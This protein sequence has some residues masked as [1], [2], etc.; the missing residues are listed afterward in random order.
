MIALNQCFWLSISL[1]KSSKEEA[2]E[3]SGV[4]GAGKAGTEHLQ[5]SLHH[6]L[7]KK[8]TNKQ[9]I[10]LWVLWFGLVLL[11]NIY[12]FQANFHNNEIF[13]LCVLGIIKQH[14]STMLI[15]SSYLVLDSVRLHYSIF[16]I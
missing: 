15:S 11:K 7:P 2:G 9:K 13:Y 5:G 1:L 10:A 8:K 16:I 14:V 4:G 3:H 12:M 6:L